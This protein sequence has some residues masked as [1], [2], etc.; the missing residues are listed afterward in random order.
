MVG[1]GDRTAIHLVGAIM[2][3]SS[4]PCQAKAGAN[5]DVDRFCLVSPSAVDVEDTKRT[6]GSVSFA[7]GILGG[8]SLERDVTQRRTTNIT[9]D[10][11]KTRREQYAIEC[12]VEIRRGKSDDE[13]LAISNKIFAKWFPELSPSKHLDQPRFGEAASTSSA[14]PI[15][16]I[17]IDNNPLFNPDIRLERGTQATPPSQSLTSADGV[18]TFNVSEKVGLASEKSQF[19]ANEARLALANYAQAQAPYDLTIVSNFRFTCDVDSLDLLVSVRLTDLTDFPIYDSWEYDK[20]GKRVKVPTRKARKFYIVAANL[21]GEDKIVTRHFSSAYVS[22]KGGST[23]KFRNSTRI[24][25]EW[26]CVVM[27]FR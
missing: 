7:G 13:K 18:I 24:P 16:D 15:A 14:A 21:I 9:D 4:A 10:S 25:D 22:P 17:H 5:S 12:R 23:F 1:F 6:S 20:T 8:G 19:L 11:F 3:F 26:R 27:V 2:I